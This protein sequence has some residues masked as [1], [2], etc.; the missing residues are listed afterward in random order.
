LALSH[1]GVLRG[2]WPDGICLW[3][4]LLLKDISAELATD[5]VWG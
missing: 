1:A 4:D 2:I 5:K 3:L